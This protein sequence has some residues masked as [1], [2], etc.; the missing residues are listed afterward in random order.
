[1]LDWIP[2]WTTAEATQAAA[3][4]AVA[5]VLVNLLLVVIGTYQLAAARKLREDQTRPFVHVGTELTESQTVRVVIANIG[6]TMARRVR[7]TFP[8]PLT[9]SLK[10]RDDYIDELLARLTEEIPNLA[11]GQ[12]IACIWDALEAR[13]V[14]G[15]PLRY[16]ATV[17][18]SGEPRRRFL[19]K[20]SPTYDDAFVLDVG[21]YRGMNIE[22][23]GVDKIA[24]E[25]HEHHDWLRQEARTRAWVEKGSPMP[26]GYVAPVDAV[27]Q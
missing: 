3:L 18:Y 5:S 2:D 4:A 10:S 22:T 24:K 26:E 27:E 19:R 1:M 7:V 14:S 13:L 25:L 16:E 20:S 23:S 9:S 12:R 17:T 21:D 15:L 11:P 6:T 8:T